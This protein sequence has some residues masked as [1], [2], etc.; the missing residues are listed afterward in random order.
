[1]TR[2]EYE[3][4]MERVLSSAERLEMYGR[5]TVLVMSIGVY[6]D[7]RRYEQNE[8]LS[9]MNAEPN[10]YG[11]YC[12]MRIGIIN[13]S[14]DR[15]GGNVENMIAPA[16]VGMTYNTDIYCPGDIIVVSEENENRLYQMTNDNPA[17]FID[18]G[19]S[20]SF[21]F[22]NHTGDIHYDITNDG[23]YISDGDTYVNI[24]GLS[25]AETVSDMAETAVST[26]IAMNNLATT[27]NATFTQEDI[28]RIT[29]ALN[30]AYPMTMY[31]Y[32][33]P[34]VAVETMTAGTSVNFTRE[35]SLDMRSECR[36]R[37]KKSREQDLNPGDTKL[38]DDFLNS[39]KKH[40]VMQMGG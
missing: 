10:T 4:T 24:G 21:D 7:I 36:E 38:M 26:A 9:I 14:N 11:E 16:M 33:A 3:A 12:G 17:Q 5:E 18:M 22:V 32:T 13:E 23:L 19:L 28:E 35:I 25:L 1:M 8:P 39:F 34:T 6:N 40:S 37:K 30:T 20:V 31:Q 2:T 29:E 15:H 27:I